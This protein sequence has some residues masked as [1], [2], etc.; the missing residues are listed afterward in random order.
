MGW[1]LW[2]ILV[3]FFLRGMFLFVVVFL[4]CIFRWERLTTA[5]TFVKMV[6]SLTSVQLRRRTARFWRRALKTKPGF[7]S[8][9]V[10]GSGDVPIPFPIGMWDCSSH[11]SIL[12]ASFSVLWWYTEALFP[13][14]KHFGVTGVHPLFEILC[15]NRHMAMPLERA[16]SLTW[17][18][19]WV[20]ERNL[21]VDRC[22]QLNH[23]N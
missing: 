17:S 23:S 16:L 19:S 1:R 10:L 4:P 22:Q 13:R 8:M 7:Y 2:L 18:T 12:P 20:T 15:H 14:G 11:S 21:T 9:S 3:F 6:V 5:C